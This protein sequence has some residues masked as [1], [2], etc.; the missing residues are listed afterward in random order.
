MDDYRFGGQ[1]GVGQLSGAPQQQQQVNIE[2][3]PPLGGAGGGDIGQD[4]RT[5]MIQNAAY[6]GSAG[7]GAFG[8]NVHQGRNGMSSPVESQQDSVSERL[9]GT[10]LRDDR[11]AVRLPRLR[12]QFSVCL[13]FHRRKG[14]L[15]RLALPHSAA[16]L[17][18]RL[19]NRAR[20]RMLS[21]HGFHK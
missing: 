10:V 4:R 21:R 15:A 12:I 17:S 3:F 1:S 6:G 7:V 5:G 20:S 9:G 11:A 2:E 13:L 18:N 8:N 16:S 14:E 19:R